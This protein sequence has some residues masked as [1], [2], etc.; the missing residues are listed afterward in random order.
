MVFDPLLARLRQI[1]RQQW[2]LIAALLVLAALLFYVNLTRNPYEIDWIFTYQPAAL[3]LAQ[4]KSPFTEVE[5][6]FTSPWALIPLLPFALLPSD[7]GRSLWFVLSI[8]MFAWIA[9]KMGAKPI[10]LM[11][12]L[13]CAP[14]FNCLQTGNIE[15]LVLLGYILP[16]QIGLIFLAIKP[17]STFIAILYFVV[18]AWR[19]GGIRETLRVV[20]PLAAIG[21]LSL[22][23]FGLW[24]LKALEIFDAAGV[25]N[26]S[27]WPQGIPI[28]MLLA[29]KAFRDRKVQPAM[30][31]SPFLSTYSILISWTGPAAAFVGNSLEMAVVCIGSW[32]FWIIYQSG[33]VS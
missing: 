20:W 19:K 29:L 32:I 26:I 5:L 16:P 1:T 12:F 9:Y 17:Q 4:G 21:A 14:V 18:E 11:A 10:G 30:M 23:I 28:G 24:P 6:F 22:L 27:I 2:L 8:G 13:F 25:Y 3:A 33:V 7:I 31:A 15:W